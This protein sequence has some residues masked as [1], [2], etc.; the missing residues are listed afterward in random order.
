MYALRPRDPPRNSFNPAS[1]Y[2]FPFSLLTG[3]RNNP[4]EC[5]VEKMGNVTETMDSSI[6]RSVVKI[7]G[8]VSANNY[9]DISGVHLQGNF[10]YLQVVVSLTA[11]YS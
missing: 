1:A 5:N 11:V 3:A 6:G 10:V 7:K 8:S 2:R 9:M 4:T